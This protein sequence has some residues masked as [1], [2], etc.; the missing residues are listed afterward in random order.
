MDLREALVQIDAIANQVARSETFRGYRALTVGFTGVIALVAA[1]MQPWLIA[2]PEQNLAAYLQLW[3]GLAVLSV[4][5]VA[6]ELTIHCYRAPSQFARRQTR[7]AVEQFLPCI[8]AGGALTWALASVA[9]D[10]GALLPGLW[11][12]V[13]SLGVFS[14]SRQLPPAIL[15]VGVYYLAAG[16]AAI[17][18]A[19]GEFAFSPWA[20][21]GTFGVGQLLTSAILYVTLERRHG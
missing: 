20:M 6:V 12:I 18:W 17:A 16:I 9:P 21:A 13:F 10:S 5:I 2:H 11:S 15:A 1:A 3:V 19:R 14:S 4:T 8:A 7:Q